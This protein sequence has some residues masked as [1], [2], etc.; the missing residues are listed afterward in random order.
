MF[1]L[2]SASARQILPS[3]PGLSSIVRMN[4]LAVGILQT[5]LSSVPHRVQGGDD[6]LSWVGI[7]TGAK[8]YSLGF[9]ASRSTAPPPSSAKSIWS[10]SMATDIWVDFTQRNYQIHPL[11]PLTVGRILTLQSDS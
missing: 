11:A 8:S 3:V 5:L 10:R 6:I 7:G 9:R 2:R 1:T 4:S